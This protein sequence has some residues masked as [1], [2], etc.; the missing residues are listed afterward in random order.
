MICCLHPLFVFLLALDVPAPFAI[1][2]NTT[3]LIVTAPLDREERETYS[4]MLVC[5]VQTDTMIDKF[6]VTLHI[7]VYDEDDNAPYVNVTDTEDVVLEFD[8]MEVT[9]F[10]FAL[11]YFTTILYINTLL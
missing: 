7:N 2:D 1:N 11:L 9:L 3:E 10:S 6:F 8:R 4:P 5:T